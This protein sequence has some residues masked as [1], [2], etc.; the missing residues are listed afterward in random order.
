MMEKAQIHLA[1]VSSNDYKSFSL[2]YLDITE[3]INFTQYTSDIV[4]L[5]PDK[6]KGGGGGGTNNTG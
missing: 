1:I 4:N 3:E 5:I 2:A 6:N